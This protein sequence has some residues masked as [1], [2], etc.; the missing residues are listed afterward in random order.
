MSTERVRVRVGRADAGTQRESSFMGN[1]RATLSVSAGQVVRK[2]AS[3]NVPETPEQ[4]EERGLICEQLEAGA[5]GVGVGGK[6]QA[7]REEQVVLS[8][9]PRPSAPDIAA[10]LETG[11]GGRREEHS[12]GVR[13]VLQRK[14]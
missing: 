9:A 8:Q 14:K 3:H 4:R 2:R 1:G 10:V 7:E 13:D 5:G 11:P 6:G 12:G